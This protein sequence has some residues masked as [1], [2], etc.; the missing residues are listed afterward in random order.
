[1]GSEHGCIKN[2]SGEKLPAGNRTKIYLRFTPSQPD[3]QRLAIFQGGGREPMIVFSTVP[4]P[5]DKVLRSATAFSFVEYSIDEIFFIV[6]DDEGS[7]LR[8]LSRRKQ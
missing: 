2:P 6:V 4:S 1:M 3:I 5:T 7:R 8:K